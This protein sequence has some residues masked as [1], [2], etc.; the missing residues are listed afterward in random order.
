MVLH[1]PNEWRLNSPVAH[2]TEV[3]DD[4]AEDLALACYA[5]EVA[6]EG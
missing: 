4:T 6:M 5:S 2:D 3:E 1:K